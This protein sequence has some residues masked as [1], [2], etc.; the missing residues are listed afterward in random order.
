MPFCFLSDGC[1]QD[2]GTT[3]NKSGDR[4]SLSCSWSSS[5]S[6]QAFPAGGG[7]SSCFP[8]RGLR[9]TQ[10]CARQPHLAVSLYQER[11]LTLVKCFFC[12]CQQVIIFTIVWN[13]ATL[14]RIVR[15]RLSGM[16]A[17]GL[18]SCSTFRSSVRNTGTNPSDVWESS[19]V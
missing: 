7:M 13:V 3:L 8:T 19:P 14:L 16:L 17:S 5:R 18:R 10:A 4:T 1:S 6:S 2:F 9:P 12:I 11:V 15:P